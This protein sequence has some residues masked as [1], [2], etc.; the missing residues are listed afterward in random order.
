MKERGC[1]VCGDHDQKRFF[2]V[3]R[4]LCDVISEITG[5]TLVTNDRVCYAHLPKG[6]KEKYADRIHSPSPDVTVTAT[7]GAPSRGNQ[8]GPVSHSS[9]MGHGGG[10]SRRSS[11]PSPA[12]PMYPFHP[13]PPT[14]MVYRF[15]AHLRG[16][17]Q[18]IVVPA[19]PTWFV[20]DL[21]QEIQIRYS[22][23]FPSP[24]KKVWKKKSLS[25][26]SIFFFLVFSQREMFL[27]FTDTKI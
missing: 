8:G 11:F 4:E 12:F 13:L 22:A 27:F 15:H 14:G 26:S 1:N 23:L 10:G 7:R 18:T 9:P 20:S 21:A 3:K 17:S 25:F 24:A 6:W 16:S 19:D 5:Q 2:V